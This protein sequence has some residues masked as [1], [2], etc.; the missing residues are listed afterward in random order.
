[1]ILTL[2]IGFASVQGFSQ[3]DR[4]EKPKKEMKKLTPEE[5]AKK[6]TEKMTE[7]LGLDEDQASKIESINL[8]HAIEMD[9]IKLEH[10]ALKEKAKK[11]RELTESNIKKVLT[12]E[13]QVV[14]DEK[15][16]E[17]KE[18]HEEHKQKCQHK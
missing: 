10:K 7:V 16:K 17:R 12:T 5:K 13:Q 14:F 4:S 8:A 3:E 18:K 9:K 6:R 11:Q 2:L 15:R 1:M